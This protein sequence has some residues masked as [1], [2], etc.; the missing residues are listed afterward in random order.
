MLKVKKEG[1]ILEPTRLEFESKAV[2][3]P[4][5]VKKGS[6]VHMFYRAVRKN[7]VS[8]I[9]YCKLKGP[10]Q[11]VQRYKHP[12]LC[13]EFNYDRD[14]LEDPMITYIDKKYYMLYTVYD[15]KNARVAYAISKD[16]KN[17]KKQS[18]ITPDITYDEAEDL[19]RHSR[20]KHGKL[21]DKYFFFEAYFK[22]SVGKDVL[23]WEKDLM[24]FPKKI[25][26]KYALLHRIL[27]DIQ[28][29]Y[30]KDLKD[31]TLHYWKNYLR[32]LSNYIVLSSKYWYESRNVGGGAVPI[33]TSKGW[34]LIYHGI[35]RYS[36]KYRLGAALLESDN[37]SVVLARLEYPIL[38]PETEHE[39]RGYRPDTVFSNGA[40]ILNDKLFIY[41]G[42]GDQVIDVVTIT[43]DKLLDELKKFH[44]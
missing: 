25:N 9:G 24:L 21:K 14:G 35:S 3:N 18:V 8:S 41:T 16:L 34:L 6:Y 37:P 4:T 22:D 10:L 13:P 30:F 36:K 7:N 12:I 20:E 39:K 33:E 43:L 42:A 2:L 15:G 5:C 17:F 40:V 44:I 1:V 11:V 28:I 27:P 23:L 26:G 38:E 31:L 29:I 32:H 19:F